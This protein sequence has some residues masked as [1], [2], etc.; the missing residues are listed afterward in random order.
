MYEKEENKD[1]NT[2]KI[3]DKKPYK[4]KPKEIFKMTNKK[5]K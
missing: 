3:K 4:P 5:I 2:I 1:F